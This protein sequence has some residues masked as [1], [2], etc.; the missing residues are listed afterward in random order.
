MRLCQRPGLQG[1]DVV[2]CGGGILTGIRK[3]SKQ[4]CL[5]Q[6]ASLLLC[7]QGL[8]IRTR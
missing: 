7:G 2:S 1:S 8:L 5:Q 6:P 4:L 3:G